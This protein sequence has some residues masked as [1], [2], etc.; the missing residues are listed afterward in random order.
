[1]LIYYLEQLVKWLILG[2]IAYFVWGKLRPKSP[3]ITSM[4]TIGGD[5]VRSKVKFQKRLVAFTP[6][7]F[8]AP[9]RQRGIESH[10]INP[11]CLPGLAAKRG[12]GLPELQADVLEQ[13][14]LIRRCRRAA[15]NHLQHQAQMG[16]EPLAE[17]GF[18][19][20]GGH[21]MGRQSVK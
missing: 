10:P 15:T 11:R 3:S 20:V 8:P 2:G 17:D 18:L 5:F 16:V 1:M 6:P 4:P 21:G 19:F 7:P 9:P 14:I 13:I 12:D